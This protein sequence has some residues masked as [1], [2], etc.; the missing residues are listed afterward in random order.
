MGSVK[1]YVSETGLRS[2]MR[3]KSQARKE[4]LE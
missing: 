3:A 2:H 4:S 1:L